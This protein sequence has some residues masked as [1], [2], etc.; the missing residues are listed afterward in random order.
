MFRLVENV[1]VVDL[2]SGWIARAK[3]NQA[4]QSGRP[5]EISAPRQ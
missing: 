3:G 5:R 1:P 4:I 2:D